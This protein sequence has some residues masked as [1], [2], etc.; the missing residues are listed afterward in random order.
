MSFNLP[1]L[2]L[3]SQMQSENRGYTA[4]S[5]IMQTKHDTVKRRSQ[6]QVTAV[7][8]SWSGVITRR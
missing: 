5:N 8:D 7:N 6:Y 4:V 2:L 1:H 3:R